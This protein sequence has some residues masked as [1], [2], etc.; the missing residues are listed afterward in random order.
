MQPRLLSSSD[1]GGESSL[2]VEGG[3]RRE[4]SEGENEVVTR[5]HELIRDIQVRIRD[6]K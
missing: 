2:E 1:D 6:L 4:T 3:E 5:I